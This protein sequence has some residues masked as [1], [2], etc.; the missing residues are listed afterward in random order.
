[1]G[2]RRSLHTQHRDVAGWDRDGIDTFPDYD[3]GPSPDDVLAEIGLYIVI[4]LGAVVAIN[5]VLLALHVAA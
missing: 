4:V 5:A 3:T 1:M 2:S